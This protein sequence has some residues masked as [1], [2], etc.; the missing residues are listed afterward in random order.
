MPARWLTPVTFATRRGNPVRATYEHPGLIRVTHWLTMI[1]LF[2]MAGSGLQ[3]LRAFPAFGPKV[4]EHDVVSIPR[5]LGLGGWL[6]GGLRWHFTFMWVFAGAGV[7]YVVT[8]AITGRYRMVLFRPRDLPGVW[9]M[10]RHYFLFGP[11]PPLTEPYNPLQK[12]AYTSTILCATL[13]VLTGLVLYKPV[14][15]SPLAFV[16]GGYHLARIWHFAAMCGLLAF[17]PGHVL[18]V[19]VHGWNNFA[20]MV[21]G[22]NRRPEYLAE[23]AAAN[24]GLVVAPAPPAPAIASPP[25]QDQRSGEEDGEENVQSEAASS[26]P[27]AASL[28]PETATEVVVIRDETAANGMSSEVEPQPVMTAVGEEDGDR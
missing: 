22:W 12:L 21:T 1:A 9:P 3:I 26:E 7:L 27:A 25:A 11:K 18:M 16:F 19:A 20:A 14:Q 4:P 8:Q 15:F 2:V 23:E 5:A 13:S 6:A 28:E 17:V 10:V 24:P